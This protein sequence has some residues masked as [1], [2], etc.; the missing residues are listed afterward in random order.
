MSLSFFFL[1]VPSL[2]F[3]SYNFTCFPVLF[4]A[5]ETL[6]QCWTRRRNRP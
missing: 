1:V 4:P 5:V 2:S 3:S 6:H